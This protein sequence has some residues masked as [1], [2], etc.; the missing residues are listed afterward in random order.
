[1]DGKFDTM[2][3]NGSSRLKLNKNNTRKVFWQ[4]CGKM[5]IILAVEKKNEISSI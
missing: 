4:K 5:I 3:G 1:M 2:S